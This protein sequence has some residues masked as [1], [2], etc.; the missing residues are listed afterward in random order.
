MPPKRGKEVF[1]LSKPFSRTTTSP[2]AS[3]L[4]CVT[5]Q[6]DCDRLIRAGK[7]LADQKGWPVQVLCVLPTAAAGQA[8]GEE[9]EDLR[10]TARDY[11]ADMNIYFH[12]DSAGCAAQV[13]R[14]Y[15]ARIIFTGMAAEPIN[16]L[17][18]R[19]RRLLPQTPIAMVDKQGTVYRMDPHQVAHTR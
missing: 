7:E 17:I 15:H 11:Q 3:V 14:S 6:R 8:L 18:D 13:A 1:S 9:L 4:V 19:L 2:S 12:D 5:G 10:S 16:G